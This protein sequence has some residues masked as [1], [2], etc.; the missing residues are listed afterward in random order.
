MERKNDV[1]IGSIDL[2]CLNGSV[3]TTLKGKK[4]IV[5]PV[6]LNPCVSTWEGRKGVKA[7]LDISIR[8]SPHNSYGNT[9]FIKASV[10]RRNRE[11]LGLSQEALK[12][13]TPILGNLKTFS[14]EQAAQ[15]KPVTSA[16]ADDED[17]PDW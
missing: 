7:S 5:I 6:E 9:H 15:F 13:C 1:L 10:S 3:L 16:L 4:C 2:M 12:D 11:S 17:L 8:E 14:R